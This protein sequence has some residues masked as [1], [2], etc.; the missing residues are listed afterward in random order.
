MK[1]LARAMKR[2]RISMIEQMADDVDTKF[3]EHFDM[4]DGDYIRF[5]RLGSGGSYMTRGRI[6]SVESCFFNGGGG[7]TAAVIVVPMLMGGGLGRTVLID[8]VIKPDGS[9]LQHLVGRRIERVAKPLDLG[10]AE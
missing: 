5:E 7:Y 8:M 1:S 10:A 9:G 6:M 4:E 2:S 3:K